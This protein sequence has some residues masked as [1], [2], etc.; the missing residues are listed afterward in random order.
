MVCLDERNWKSIKIW[1]QVKKKVD[2]KRTLKALKTVTNCLL[3]FFRE[4][5]GAFDHNFLP[6]RSYMLSQMINPQNLTRIG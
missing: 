5:F 4:L 2:I 6:F 1:T 3:L